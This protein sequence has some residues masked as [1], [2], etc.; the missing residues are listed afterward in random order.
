MIF[1]VVAVT[2]LHAKI[3]LYFNFECEGLYLQALRMHVNIGFGPHCRD[4][5][6]TWEKIMPERHESSFVKARF[7][8]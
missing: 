6:I 7:R 5:V 2:S 1:V 4:G 3:T 8:L